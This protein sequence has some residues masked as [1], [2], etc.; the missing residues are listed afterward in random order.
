MRLIKGP[1]GEP[2]EQADDGTTTFEYDART[3]AISQVPDSS[4]P[5]LIDPLSIVR[6][7][8]LDGR[9]PVAG[10]VTIDGMSL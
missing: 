10:T 7:Q 4:R 6:Q 9:A 3:N 8:L 1:I 5:T 2:G